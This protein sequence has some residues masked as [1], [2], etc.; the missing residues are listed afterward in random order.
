M[1]DP[2]YRNGKIYKLLDLTNGNIYIGSTIQRLSKRLYEHKSHY[3]SWLK[4]NKHYTSSYEIIKNGNYKILLLEAYPCNNKHELE[5]KE[6]EYIV[7]T[8]CVNKVMPTRTQKQYQKQYKRKDLEKRNKKN[9]CACGGSYTT[10]H[11]SDHKKSKRHR[12]YIFNLH[13]EL[14]HL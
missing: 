13:N 11:I 6:Y 5:L 10:C 1:T 8:N 14:N 7:A 12:L 3:K 9:K 4:G 2:R